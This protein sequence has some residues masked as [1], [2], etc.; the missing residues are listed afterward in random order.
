MKKKNHSHR[1]NLKATNNKQR[2]FKTQ[3]D[4]LDFGLI[5]IMQTNKRSK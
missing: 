2:Q 3:E 4:I 1:Q 5:R